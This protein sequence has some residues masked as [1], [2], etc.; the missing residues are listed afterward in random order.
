MITYQTL[1]KHPKD[2]LSVTGLTLEEFTGLC[3]AFA[4][5]YAAAY[6]AECRMDGQAR[7]RRAGAGRKPHLVTAEDK[8]LFILAYHKQYALQTFHALQFGMSQGRA[9]EW[10]HR[11]SPLLQR[12]LE[13]I[14]MAPVRAGEQVADS[15]LAH[16]GS[17]DLL[18]DGTERRRQRPGAD[19]AQ[20]THYSGKKKSHSDK[21]LVVSNAHSQKVVYLSPTVGGSIHDKKLADASSIVYPLNATLSKDTGFQGYTPQSVMVL[22]PKKSRKAS[23]CMVPKSG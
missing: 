14:G 8:L 1:K 16:E 2:F 7:L 3:Q 4:E 19:T 17:P 6:P 11:L 10:I 23:R 20:R 13:Q 12:T 22:Q 21:N 15:P 18:I 9:N 5:V